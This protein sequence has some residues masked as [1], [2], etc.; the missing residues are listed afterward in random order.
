MKLKASI[1]FSALLIVVLGLTSKK[2]S[3]P[4]LGIVS[5]LEQDSLAYE[6]GFRVIGESVG[7]MLSPSLTE[8]LFWQNVERIKKAK[9]KVY[10]CNVFFPGTIKIAGPDVD[11]KRVISYADTVLSRAKQA[12]IPFIILGSGGPRRIPDGFDK[13]KA[14]VDFIILCKKTGDTCGQV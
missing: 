4:Q 7:R 11:Q 9:C 14:K 12:G 1:L 2:N 13:D 6:S 10:L 3:A 5:R 8:E